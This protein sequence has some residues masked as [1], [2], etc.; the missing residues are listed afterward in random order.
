[1]LQHSMFDRWNDPNRTRQDGDCLATWWLCL[2]RMVTQ[3]AKNAQAR[4]TVMR[5]RVQDV[6]PQAP[7]NVWEWGH[8]GLHNT[9]PPKDS[10]WHAKMPKKSHLTS[11]WSR[12]QHL[13]SGV[14]V[15]L[16]LARS[17]V[18]RLPSLPSRAA[19]APTTVSCFNV[20]PSQPV[21][22][23]VA[24]NETFAAL[25]IPDYPIRSFQSVLTEQLA[26]LLVKGYRPGEGVD[27]DRWPTGVHC[28]KVLPYSCLSSPFTRLTSPSTS[29]SYMPCYYPL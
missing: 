1:M 5:N 13:K 27:P 28:D 16:F 9:P 8:M 24:S 14:D 10:N 3:R 22:L 19:V 6:E 17:T 26:P 4:A 25:Q 23:K 11:A 12:C 7:P 15:W 2:T 20:H 18:Q 21:L 29:I